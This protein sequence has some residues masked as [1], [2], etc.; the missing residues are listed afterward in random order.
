MTED[1]QHA[2]GSATTAP[3]GQGAAAVTGAS[4]AAQYDG[5]HP[6]V[7]LVGRA[8]SGKTALALALFGAESQPTA[9]GASARYQ[10]DAAPVVVDDL[11]G[12]V[13]GEEGSVSALFSYLEH[14]DAA[15]PSLVAIW[16]ALDASSARVTDYELELIRRLAQLFPVVVVLTRTDLVSAEARDAM[17]AAIDGA[18]IANCLGVVAAAAD[19]LPALGMAPYGIADV[20]ALTPRRALQARYEPPRAHA[21]VATERA[22]SQPETQRAST[23][24]SPGQSAAT[25]QQFA[26]RSEYARRDRRDEE[27][28]AAATGEGASSR[29]LL[30][31]LVVFALALALVLL[32]RRRRN[33]ESADAE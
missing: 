30:V 24:G 2:Q 14:A 11:P 20:V 5:R 6:H 17:R 15:G 22:A 7:A 25:A 31:V 28:Y 4:A 29:A 33:Q 18:S 23:A 32:G 10:S 19:P 26:T 9:T 21:D 3:D 16:Y 12:W 8:G 27:A 13:N 1:T